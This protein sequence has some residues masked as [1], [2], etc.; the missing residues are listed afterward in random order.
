MRQGSYNR[1]QNELHQLKAANWH[2]F[3][4]GGLF[5]LFDA[6]ILS[7]HVLDRAA[8]A[9]AHAYGY[10][11]K[12]EIISGLAASFPGHEVMSSLH[13]LETLMSRGVI[14]DFRRHD[15][16]VLPADLI[17]GQKPLM[18]VKALCLNV[19]HDCNLRCRY[20][21]ASSGNFGGGPKLMSGEVARR[22]IDF[23]LDVSGRRKHCEVDF[24]GGEPLVNW[25]VVRDTVLYGLEKAGALGKTVKFTITTNAT[26]LDD[27]KIE[28]IK[29]Y[30]MD[31][32]LSLDGRP[33]V[34]DRMRTFADGR[35]TYDTVSRNIRRYIEQKGDEAYYVR[36]TYT[37][38]N[39]DFAA[40]VMHLA[41]LGAKSISVEPV[42]ASPEEPYSI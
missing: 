7:L 42:V 8:W 9:V 3:R 25:P 31:I 28:F 27:E 1:L 6:R 37:R 36:G 14:T 13:E 34:N 41:D 20:C 21:F 22:S 5:L 2:L 35:P 15:R 10:Q 11:E 39:L 12:A 24:F 30:N 33:E 26:L 38:Y 40:D 19:A 23:L 4:E 18:P 16:E 32:V 17:P 29:R